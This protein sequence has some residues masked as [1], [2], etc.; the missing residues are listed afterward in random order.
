MDDAQTQN[1]IL[2]PNMIPETGAE[3][4]DMEVKKEQPEMVAPEAMP[5][6]EEGEVQSTEE[7]AS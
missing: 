6:T 3:N 5:S 1:P 4:A 2:D 7:S